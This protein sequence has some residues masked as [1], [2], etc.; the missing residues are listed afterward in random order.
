VG[1]VAAKPIGA[2]AVGAATT[3]ATYDSITHAD[4]IL[5]AVR[6]E[7]MFVHA[8]VPETVPSAVA[9]ILDKALAN[10]AAFETKLENWLVQH[11]NR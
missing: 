2:S 1:Q 3:G 5:R 4:L 9:P 8:R 6:G 10:E 11:R 7:N